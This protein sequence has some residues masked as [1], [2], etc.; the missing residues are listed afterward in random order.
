MM[1]AGP[2]GKR[3]GIPEHGQEQGPGAVGADDL[4]AESFIDQVRDPVMQVS[5]PRWVMVMVFW[6]A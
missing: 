3:H 5:A 1:T 2:A 4:T 6:G